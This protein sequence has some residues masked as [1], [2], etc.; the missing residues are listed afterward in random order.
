LATGD[1]E[2]IAEY[3]QETPEEAAKHFWASPG[4]LVMNADGVIRRVGSITPQMRKGRCVF[5]DEHNRCRIHAVAP[6]GCSHFDTHMPYNVAH[7][8]SVWLAQSTMEPRYQ[9]LRN[10]LPYA[11]SY[12]PNRY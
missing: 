3:L 11:R 12:K 10:E 8:R 1:F 2:R 4:A 9:A 6:F 5:L 7:P